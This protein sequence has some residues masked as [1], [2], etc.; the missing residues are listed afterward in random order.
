[1]GKS[2]GGMGGMFRQMQKQAQDMQKRM[3]TVQED[4]KQRVYEGTAGGG[5]VTTMVNG[6]REL[7]AVKID[8]EVIDPKDASMLEDLVAAAVNAGMKKAEEAYQQEI[9]K[10]TGG[11]GLPGMF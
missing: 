11:L 8:P 1:M 5:M 7:L 4:M 9:G 10:I 6:K 2:F 3:G